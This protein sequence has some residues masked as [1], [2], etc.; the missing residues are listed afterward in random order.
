MKKLFIAFLTAFIMVQCTI[1]VSAENYDSATEF[2]GY[3]H[4][5][6]I[7][8]DIDDLNTL[9]H[10][11]IQ[12]EMDL[13]VQEKRSFFEF[14]HKLK[15]GE[16]RNVEVHASPSTTLDGKKVLFSIIHDVTD[17]VAAKKK[18]DN[19]DFTVT[20]ILAI[21]V[22]GLLV[23]LLSTNKARRIAKRSHNRL[24]S[25]FE[26]M[27][28]SF[29]VHEIICDENNKP[30]NYKFLDANHAFE[31]VTGFKIADIRNKTVL[32]VM[33]ETESYWIE[34][35]GE[36]AITG[37]PISFIN[38]SK[39]IGKY[40][41]V[42]VYRPN[43]MRFA[44]FASDI[45]EQ[46]NLKN[47]IEL[48]RHMLETILEDTMSGYWDW[49][50]VNDTQYY[51]PSF[52]RMLGYEPEELEN[53]P[54]TWQRLAYDEDLESV[55]EKI[56]THIK[57]FGKI[58]F[59]T[60][61]RYHHKDGSL[62]WVICSGRVV[63]WDDDK[64]PLRMV[65]S[66]IEITDIKNLEKTLRDERTLFKTTLHSLGDGVI[67]TDENGKV[68]LMNPVAEKLTGWSN[69][70]A[71]GMEFS[72]VFNIINEFTRE[73]CDNPVR[74][75][76]ETG[77]II[78]L[79][80]HTKLIK[81]NKDELPIEDS[82]APIFDENGDVS[83]VVLVFRDFTDKKEKHDRILYLSYHDQLT[84]LYNR[85]FF[86]EEQIRLDTER[87]YPLTL[88]MLDVNGLKLTNDAFG[89]IAGD[90]LLKIVA[91]VLTRECRADDI[92]ARIGGDEF[93]ILLPQTPDVETE[94]IVKRIYSAI[95][96][97]STGKTI[98]SV[99]IGWATKFS[100]DEKMSDVFVLAEE[101]M[102]RKKLTESQSMRHRT[103]TA[104]INTLNEKNKREKVHSE[105]VAIICKQIGEAMEFD[106]DEIK[107]IE[108]A[109][110]MHD[111]GKISIKES[112][113]DKPGKLTEAEYS[114]VKRHPESS[115]Q[116]LKSV[117]S[118]S[119]L[120]EYA[121]SHHER[122]DGKGYPR[123]LKG[124]EIPIISRII[125][126]ADAFEAMTADRTYRKAMD[127]DIALAEL[128]RGAGT[129]FDENI[130][131]IFDEKVFEKLIKTP[132]AT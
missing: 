128:K 100:A 40:F 130:V 93:V 55:I 82:A 51:S 33:P 5:E 39:Q 120:A 36:V 46:V 44:T 1:F 124:E 97:E 71:K 34:K 73:P 78:E 87:N 77:K 66:H 12:A 45:T 79:A 41:S 11:K 95:Q 68:K 108:L 49:D 50:V 59:Y 61:V 60:H 81:K 121:L 23:S 37:K 123:G 18:A 110:L 3:T 86:E 17:I 103:V 83:G 85:R 63:E 113:L 126:V 67:S 115:Y 99:S 132:K 105:N 27:R 131:K 35:Y 13:A 32:E 104:I 76:F 75:V 116:I 89:H 2:Y 14:T 22:F 106:Y 94:K 84:G 42:S 48:E 38:Y 10:E 102:Y 16:I 80:N 4:E 119:T 118:Y 125:S 62:V 98:I 72:T 15:N 112:L 109:G 101:Y 90:S 31:E 122:W 19:R 54:A 58:P 52:K 96:G 28:E 117:D 70:E 53:I 107:E 88:A 57:S 43:P 24:R 7:G 64:N 56:E 25:V 29:S 30:I 129:Q 8:M 47:K 69:D 114:E 26:N 127:N 111:I 6:F 20:V 74:R 65:G 92:I 9:S 91:D 21:M